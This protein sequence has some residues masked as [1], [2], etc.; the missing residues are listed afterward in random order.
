MQGNTYLIVAYA[1][2]W[3]GLFVYLAFL[4]MRLRGVRTELAA[5]EQL[6]HEHEEQHSPLKYE[7]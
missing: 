2:A 5:V 4:A 1:I 3:L 7:E 6:V